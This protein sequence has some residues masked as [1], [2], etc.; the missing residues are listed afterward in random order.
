M[1]C[2]GHRELVVPSLIVLVVRGLLVVGW[3][4]V[5]ASSYDD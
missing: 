5:P 1:K 3:G 4:L 2:F